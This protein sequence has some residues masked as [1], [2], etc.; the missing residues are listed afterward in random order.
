MSENKSENKKLREVL[1]RIR[2]HVVGFKS[3]SEI[4]SEIDGALGEVGE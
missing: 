3:N 4:L 1:R 2:H